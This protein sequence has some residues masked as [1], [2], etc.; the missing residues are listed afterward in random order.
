MVSKA[1][2]GELDLQFKSIMRYVTQPD[3]LRAGHEIF[4]KEYT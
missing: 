2:F 3:K 1:K 4:S